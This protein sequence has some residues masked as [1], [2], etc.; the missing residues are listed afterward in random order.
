MKMKE[1]LG[2]GWRKRLNYDKK[3]QLIRPQEF[4][5]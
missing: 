2:L 3:V 1:K 5:D 4:D